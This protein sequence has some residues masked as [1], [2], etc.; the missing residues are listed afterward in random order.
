[1]TREVRILFVEDNEG[2][3]VLTTEA[4]KEARISNHVTVVRD[5]E[6]ALL[7][8]LRKGKY[9][10][11][12]RPDLI[13]LD[14]NLPKIDGKEVL[15]RIKNDPHLM[16]IPVVI[17]TTSDSEKDIMDSYHNHA[18]CYITKPVDF[19]KFMDVVHTIKDFWI[20]IV[21]LP[22]THTDAINSN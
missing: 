15:A 3:I 2:D 14:I 13:L 6:E 5:G 22:K 12:E 4:M 18:N 1:M 8:L 11:A 21:Q 10:E 17:L 19:T 7:F 9:A 16:T 20:S